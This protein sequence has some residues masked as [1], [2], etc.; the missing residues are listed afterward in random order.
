MVKGEERISEKNVKQKKAFELKFTCK[1][2]TSQSDPSYALTY[3]FSR[4]LS[5]VNLFL[6]L[7]KKTFMQPFSYYI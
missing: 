6:S 4:M 5:R 3:I 1:S 2:N 7:P